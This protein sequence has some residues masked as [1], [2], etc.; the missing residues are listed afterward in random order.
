LYSSWRIEVLVWKNH[1]D[2]SYAH[3]ELDGPC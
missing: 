2:E 3:L 1:G